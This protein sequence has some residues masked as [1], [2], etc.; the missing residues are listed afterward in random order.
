MGIGDAFGTAM[1]TGI[2]SLVDGTATAQEVFSSFLKTIGQTLL[3][4]AQQMIAT[5]IAIGIAKMFAGLGGGFSFKGAGPVSGSSVFGSG[6][7]GF[8]PIAF[9]T[10]RLAANGAV[11]Q[12]GFTPFANGGVVNGPTLGLIGEGRYNEAIVLFPMARAFP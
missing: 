11:W 7:A 5:Y 3:Q 10:P 9:S 6:Q 8:N 2:A 4:A 12:G 1:T